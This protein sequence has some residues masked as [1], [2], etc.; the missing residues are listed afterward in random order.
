MNVKNTGYLY[1]LHYLKTTVKPQ[2]KVDEHLT[3]YSE[4]LYFLNHMKFTQKPN[5]VGE[6]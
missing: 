2:D 3:N 4:E 6:P 1:L 5:L